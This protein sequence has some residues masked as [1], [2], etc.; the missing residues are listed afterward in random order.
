MV[1][2]IQIAIQ[3]CNKIFLNRD[4][5]G[6]PPWTKCFYSKHA[7]N[8]IVFVL[9]PD[10][11]KKKKIIAL[12]SYFSW[13]LTGKEDSIGS[14]HLYAQFYSQVSKSACALFKGFST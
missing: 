10:F 4:Q 1:C 2:A 14:L 11:L 3:N 8:T 6:D 13:V 5:H 12:F 7:R 9:F